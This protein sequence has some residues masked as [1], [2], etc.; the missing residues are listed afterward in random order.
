MR[1]TLKEFDNFGNFSLIFVFSS[2][3]YPKPSPHHTT[4]SKS[5]LIMNGYIG[6]LTRYISLGVYGDRQ[7]RKGEHK[8]AYTYR[9]V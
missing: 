4:G 3:H 9:P 2:L 5:L 8:Y 7:I 1:I 6:L